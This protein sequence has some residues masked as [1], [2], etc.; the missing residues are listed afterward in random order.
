MII[1]GEISAKDTS[2]GP[3]MFFNP[4]SIGVSTGR[5]ALQIRP[6]VPL[7]YERRV[8]T[9]TAHQLSGKPPTSETDTGIPVKDD[10]NLY[11]KDHLVQEPAQELDSRIDDGQSPQTRYGSEE[12]LESHIGVLSQKPQEVEQRSEV[13]GLLSRGDQEEAEEESLNEAEDVS[14]DVDEELLTVSLGPPSSIE[15]ISEG[16]SI[17]YDP[18]KYPGPYAQLPDA[19][20]NIAQ[21]PAFPN[22]WTVPAYGPQVQSHFTQ[23]WIADHEMSRIGGLAPPTPSASVDDAGTSIDPK[24]VDHVLSSFNDDSY[25]DIRLTVTHDKSQFD[26]TTFYLHR[27]LV[28]RSKTVRNIPVTSKAKDD[29]TNIN[30][31]LRISLRDRFV[32]VNALES[33]LRTCYGQPA[34][35]FFISKDHD[36]SESHS[37]QS[38]PDMQN[39]IAYAA[40]G[41]LFQLG[42]VALQALEKARKVL[43]WVSNH[44]CSTLLT[45]P[46]RYSKILGKLFGI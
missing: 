21:A 35:T 43:G 20:G 34:S 7:I 3:P 12:G 10:G 1:G 5:K 4:S 24:F 22:G 2:Y 14:K 17:T 6:A 27:V 42:D 16:N 30:N 41:H 26:D 38:V 28:F 32:N 8:P 15:S 39:V 9:A 31:E 33:A 40:A 11:E 19:A 45:L 44:N 46:L 37:D 25:A 13:S 23:G 18:E 36:E 29:G